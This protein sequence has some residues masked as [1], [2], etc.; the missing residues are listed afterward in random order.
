MCREEESKRIARA[1]IQLADGMRERLLQLGKSRQKPRSHHII[2]IILQQP[3]VGGIANNTKALTI[4]S[5]NSVKPYFCAFSTL[6]FWLFDTH[7]GAP[8]TLARYTFH[9]DC[10]FP[11]AFCKNELYRTKTDRKCKRA[12]VIVG[13]WRVRERGGKRQYCPSV[14]FVARIVVKKK[15]R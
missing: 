8:R 1:R 2:K 15:K 6:S 4:Q 9:V 12:A 7:S 14:K 3:H 13:F 10:S 11:G 5:S